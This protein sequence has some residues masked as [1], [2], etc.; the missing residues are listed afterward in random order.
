MVDD[1][2]CFW[3]TLG[4]KPAGFWYHFL[5][6]VVLRS[7]IGFTRGSSGLHKACIAEASSSSKSAPHSSVDNERLSGM[8][9]TILSGCSETER[10]DKAIWRSHSYRVLKQ[11]QCTAVELNSYYNIHII[12]IFMYVLRSSIR[13]L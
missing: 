9:S 1:V 10:N 2:D 5:V 6:A 8:S 7:L 3:L 13:H 11:L 4:T 12:M